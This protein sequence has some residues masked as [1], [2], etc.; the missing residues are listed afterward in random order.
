MVS[1][2]HQFWA[3][4]VFAGGAVSAQPSFSQSSVLNSP[5]GTTSSQVQATSPDALA[6]N[7]WN[8]LPASYKTYVTQVLAP[9]SDTQRLQALYRLIPN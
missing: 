2:S 8:S 4:A 1:P 5:F 9:M 7:I 3:I 6:L